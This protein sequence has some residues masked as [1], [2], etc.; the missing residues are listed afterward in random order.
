VFK[1]AGGPA[2]ARSFA[3]PANS[4]NVVRPAFDAKPAKATKAPART[5]EPLQGKRTG[6]DDEWTSF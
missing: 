5:A 1:L 3:E 6:T 4:G 2:K